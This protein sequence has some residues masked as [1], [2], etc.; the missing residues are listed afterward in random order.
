MLKFFVIRGS[1]PNSF[2]G[3]SGLWSHSVCV[4]AFS[5]SEEPPLKYLIK[6]ILNRYILEI[7][8]ANK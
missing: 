2:D 8:Y 5:F 3:S 1:V 7:I 4:Q 6:K